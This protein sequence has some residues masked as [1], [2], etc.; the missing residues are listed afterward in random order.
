MCEEREETGRGCGKVD[1]KLHSHNPHTYTH[2]TPPTHIKTPGCPI[3]EPTNY[4]QNQLP[5]CYCNHKFVENILIM[6]VFLK[7]AHYKPDMYK[8]KVHR[9]IHRDIFL[10]Y[11]YFSFWR[12]LD[13]L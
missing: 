7:A 12:G 9:V 10:T 6:S 4:T 1:V 2:N 13:L 5:I 11:I 3:T 8:C